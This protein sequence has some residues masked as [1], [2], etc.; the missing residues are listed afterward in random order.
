M[1]YRKHITMGLLGGLLLAIPSLQAAVLAPGAI[2]TAPDSFNGLP[3]LGPVAPLEASAVTAATFSGTL[4]SGVFTDGV[5]GDLDFVYQ[6]TANVTAPEQGVEKITAASY[7]PSIAD[8]TFA[9]AFG[10]GAGVDMGIINVGPIPAGFVAGTFA[11]DLVTRSGDGTVV[12][13][14]F[15]GNFAIPA[16]GISDVLVVRTHATTFTMGQGGVIDSST[17]NTSV[18]APSP[19]PRLAGLAALGLFG[20]VGFFFRRRKVQATE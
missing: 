17:G 11:P 18:Y 14:N 19:E 8:G 20:L 5:T 4:L 1:I 10:A 12:G 15:D 7:N 2:P 16:G 13:F 3:L 9:D 6:Y